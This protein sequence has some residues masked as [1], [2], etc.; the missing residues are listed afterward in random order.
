VR[1]AADLNGVPTDSV[2]STK[3][4]GDEL[5]STGNVINDAIRAG[6]TGRWGSL[7]V[8]ILGEA[9]SDF[10][11]RPNADP[12]DA[13]FG[14]NV[15]PTRDTPG[16]GLGEEGGTYAGYWGPPGTDSLDSGARIMLG[17]EPV[18]R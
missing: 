6:V 13:A 17:L 2:Y 4:R 8:D 14:A 3:S 11:G 12:N 7:G 15:F 10:D 16:H 1:T 5:H 18:D 9:M